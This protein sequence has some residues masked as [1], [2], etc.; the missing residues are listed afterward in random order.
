METRTTRGVLLFEPEKKHT[1]TWKRLYLDISFVH[2][3]ET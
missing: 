3:D 2:M 1:K